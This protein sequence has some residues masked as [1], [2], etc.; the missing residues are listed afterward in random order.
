MQKILRK[1]LP[2][3]IQWKGVLLKSA[4]FLGIYIAWVIFR[5]PQAPS[6][7]FIGSLAVLVPGVTAVLLI[8]QFLPSLPPT[9]QPA[10]RFLGFGLAFWSLGNLVRTFYEG[11]RGI[12]VPTLSL[13]DVFSFLAYPLF[14]LALILYPFENRYAPSRFRFL[15]DVTISAGV[16]ATLVGLM[17]GQSASV[18]R[19]AEWIPLVYPIADLI[20]LMILFNI[21]LANRKARLTL[22]LWGGGL[23]AFLASDYLY[24][25]LAPV[26]GFQAGG[27]ESTG[28]MAGGLLFGWGAVFMAGT[29][30]G[31]DK[32]VS[33][34]FDLGTRVQN[35]LPFVLV[36][37]LD[38]VVLAEW[39]LSGQLSWLGAG[40]SLF[41]T[42]AMGVRMGVR[43]GRDRIT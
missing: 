1:I 16:V 32:P 5:S 36:L 2:W 41:L 15:L 23:L 30:A 18:Y 26:N 4:L 14:F 12:P 13:A 20:L 24:S 27:F 37:A 9:S 19:P 39:R 33:P 25:L 17:L 28:W 42:L 10:W 40:T 22:V 21:L 34:A 7:L 8:F 43:G 38:W 3:R 31:Q 35:I 29:A 11:A 6:R